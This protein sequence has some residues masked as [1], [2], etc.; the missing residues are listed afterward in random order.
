MLGSLLATDRK[1]FEHFTHDASVLPIEF[2]P[3]WRRQFQR[4][5]ARVKHS[6]FHKSKLGP[7]ELLSI[8]KR[9][10]AEGPLSTRDFDTKITGKK[11]MWSRPPHKKALDCMWYAGELAISHRENFIKFYD[12]SE[13]VIPAG[14]RAE[15]HSD[16]F[17]VDWLCD[18]ALQRLTFATTGEIQRFWDAMDAVEAKAWTER[19]T[20]KIVPVL[21]EDATGDKFHAVATAD[22]ERRLASL[23]SPTS[24]LRIVNPFDPAVRDRARLMRLFGFEYRNEMFVPVVNRKWGYYVYPILEGDRFVGRIEIT[25][26]RKLGTLLVRQIWKE[27]R[28]RWTGARADK[29]DAE[30]SRFARLIDVAAVRWLCDRVPQPAS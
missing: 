18:A 24:R 25:A 27:P 1:I 15:C 6:A 14:L 11:E 5:G 8:K 17:Q 10:S 28:V 19:N 16:G 7:E 26:N 12:L 20:S 13:R 29:L 3:V 4:L 30:L 2:Y 21:V 9:I 23:P 22:I